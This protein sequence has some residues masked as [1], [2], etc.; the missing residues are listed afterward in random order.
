[1]N[2]AESITIARSHEPAIAWPTIVLA[3][4]VVIGFCA[5]GAL[6]ASGALSLWVALPLNTLLAYAAYTP[7][8]EACHRNVVD[9]KHPLVWLNNIVGTLAA[10][11]LFGSFHLHQLTHLAHHAH[12]N[13]P[14]RDPDHWMASKSAAGLLLRG[15]TIAWIHNVAGVRLA[16]TRSDGRTRLVFA[17]LQFTAWFGAVAWLIGRFDPLA[18]I[19]STLVPAL[20][21]G[22]LLGLVF[23][24]LPHHPHAHQ[25]RWQHTRVIT[26]SPLTQRAVDVALLGQSYHLV[27]HLY[28]RVPFYQYRVVFHTLR[29]YFHDNRALIAPFGTQK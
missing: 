29:G 28:P 21:A 18:A 13:H 16:R 4:V 22:L 14:E 12:T 8:H 7:I 3:V 24:W 17:A 2:H 26:F 9:A 27:H 10:A 20:L 19:M 11:P 1:V 23:D 25:D 6:G 15:L 5:V